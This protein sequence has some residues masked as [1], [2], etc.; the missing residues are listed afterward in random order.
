MVAGRTAVEVGHIGA[1]AV[2]PTEFAA[3]MV[4]GH[5]VVGVVVGSIGSVV[6]PDRDM[7]TLAIAGNQ[8]T[9]AV[10]LAE[11]EVVCYTPVALEDRV[12]RVRHMVPE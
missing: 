3:G 5:I 9:G 6:A 10:D 4:A 7:G 8:E 2:A 11:G 12:M 1:V